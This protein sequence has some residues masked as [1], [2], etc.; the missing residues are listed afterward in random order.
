MQINKDDIRIFS[1]VP[2]WVRSIIYLAV[3]GVLC[4]KIYETPVFLQFD[5]PAFLA[6]LLALFSVALAALFYFK[7]TDTSNAFYDN[8]YKFNS[9]L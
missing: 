4:W 5:F 9:S 6:L 1:A 2:W 7:A 8:T 3:T